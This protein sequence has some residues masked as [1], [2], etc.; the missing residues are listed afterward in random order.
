MQELR[1]LSM[2]V[3][4]YI[5]NKLYGFA[6]DNNDFQVFFHLGQ[7]KPFRENGLILP[8]QPPPI[9]GEPVLV[10]FYPNVDSTKAPKGISI[11]RTQKPK[12]IMGTVESYD[13]TRGYGFIMGEDGISYHLHN[14]EILNNRYPLQGEKVKFYAGLRMGKPRACHIEV[15]R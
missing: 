5:P 13:N 15:L 3:Y 10:S 6:I 11:E 7:F 9:L 14:S 1:T 2:R 12:T 4:K 8:L